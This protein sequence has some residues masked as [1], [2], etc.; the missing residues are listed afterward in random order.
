MRETLRVRQVLAQS[1][2]TDDSFTHL[3]A[4]MGMPKAASTGRRKVG[5]AVTRSDLSSGTKSKLSKRFQ[6]DSSESDCD[7]SGGSSSGSVKNGRFDCFSRG[8]FSSGY[9]SFYESFFEKEGK[10]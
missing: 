4:S 10:V 3:V 9:F 1:K 8:F 6:V 2:T 5:T 7:K